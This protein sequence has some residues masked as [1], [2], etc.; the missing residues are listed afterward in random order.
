[1]RRALS[2]VLA[3]VIAF[4]AL[5]A[6]LVQTPARDSAFYPFPADR[7]CVVAITDDTDGFQFATAGPVYALLDSLGLRVTKTVWAFDHETGDPS[8]VG[9]SL[10]DPEYR[11]WIGGESDAGHDIA[12]HSPSCGDDNRAAILSAHER[13]LNVLGRRPRIG[14]FHGSDREALYWGSGGIPNPVVGRIYAAVRGGSAFEG[15]VPGSEFY[16]LDH[17]R[18]LVRYVRTYT[19]DGVNTLALNPSMPFEDDL[20]PLAP[21]WFASSNGRLGDRFVALLSQENVE[22]LKRQRGAAIVSTRFASDFTRSGSGQD[23]SGRSGS[24][25][26]DRDSIGSGGVGDGGRRS[27]RPDV[28][29]ALVRC[30]TDPAVEFVPAG[31]LLDRLRVIQL[32]ED[33]LAEG[34]RAAPPAGT[35]EDVGRTLHLALPRELLPALGGVSVD[36]GRLPGRFRQN[37]SPEE[38][39]VDLLP[40]LARARIATDIVPSTVFDGARRIGWR[41]RW[42]LVVRWAA[43]RAA[44]VGAS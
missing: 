11:S 10:D 2:W 15:H 30:G 14:T 42:R 17:A 7:A 9:L 23:A 25:G 31:E 32:V 40:W 24:S 5:A 35:E 39:R 26:N 12:L 4:A 34:L 44:S 27:L 41:E 1:M 18:D 8:N 38:G 20:T 28:R 19:I 16:W 22:R 21:L 6:W 3:I 37:E 13:L 43:S 29:E 36:P 33:V